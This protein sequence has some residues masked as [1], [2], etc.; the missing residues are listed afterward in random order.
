MVYDKPDT[1]GLMKRVVKALSKQGHV[2]TH[3][4]KVYVRKFAPLLFFI[5]L[6]ALIDS[7]LFLKKGDSF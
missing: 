5:F 7:R 3:R 6:A 2:A 4:R 1:S